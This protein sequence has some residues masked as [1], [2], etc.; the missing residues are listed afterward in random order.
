MS[1]IHPS[2]VIGAVVLA[3]LCIVSGDAAAKLLGE[4]GYPQTFVAWTRFSVALVIVLPFCGI[5]RAEVPLLWKPQ[6]ILRGVLIACAI[7]CILMALKSEPMANV[8]GGFFIGPIVAYGLAVFMLGERVSVMRSLLLGLSFLGVLIVVRP[9]FG[10]TVGM[11]FAMMAG[12][13]HGSYLVAT[14][15]LAGGY[16]PQFLLLSQLA[17]G[18]ICLAPFALAS[19]PN[20]TGTHVALLLWSAM[21]SALGNLILVVLSRTTPANV[22]APLIYSQLLVAVVMG[23]IVFG[24]YPDIISVLG[25][26]IIAGAGVTSLYFARKEGQ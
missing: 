19:L 13:L 23:I 12:C 3:M 18:A 14:R 4:A 24:D 9:G 25:L 6:I 10:M 16:R 11:G 5:S 15:W 20:I 26:C 21:G 2:Y 8:F 17:V 1:A 7:S 22:I